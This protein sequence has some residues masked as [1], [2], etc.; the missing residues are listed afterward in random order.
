M[1]TSTPPGTITGKGDSASWVAGEGSAFRT[2]EAWQLSLEEGEPRSALVGVTDLSATGHQWRHP[3]TR[4]AADG[5]LCSKELW[6]D[7][8]F[9][10][11][12]VYVIPEGIRNAGHSAAANTIRN[13]LQSC[14]NRA[15]EECK[16][17]NEAAAIFFSCLE[18]EVANEH[19][20]W[21]RK[22][23]DEVAK[24]AY[25]KLTEAGEE[26]DQSCTALY[27]SH[28]ESIQRAYSK[29][30]ERRKKER[31]GSATERAGRKFAVIG[32]YQVHPFQSNESNSLTFVLGSWAVWGGGRNDLWVS[33]LGSPLSG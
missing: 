8:S 1:S 3:W 18:K 12:Y 14:M 11:V 29:T 2:F 10:L 28:I 20:R 31:A 4:L 32:T 5:H 15:R 17:H 16:P 26:T 7:Y 21:W 13:Y 6:G 22:V 30:I 9:W 33:H 25:R 27:R 23:K 24:K 19:T